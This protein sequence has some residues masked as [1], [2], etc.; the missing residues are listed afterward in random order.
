MSVID[1]LN[2]A[3]IIVLEADGR[4]DSRHGY[5][6][7]IV[8]RFTDFGIKTTLVSIVENPQVL[9]RLPR[10]P[11]VLSGGM[12]EV[13]A[14]VDWVMKTKAHIFR[15]IRQNRS[16]QENRRI[17]VFG[18]CFGAQLIAECY[19]KGSVCYLENPEIGVTRITLDDP[20]HPLFDGFEP[21]FDAYTFHYN[22]IKSR[23]FSALSTHYFNNRQFIQA[24][25]IPE[26]SVFGVQFHP[27][28]NHNEMQILFKTYSRLIEKLG[29]NPKDIIESLP[30]LTG[31]SSILRNF[32]DHYCSF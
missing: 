17:P 21:Q 7:P 31:N 18:I 5:G 10:K 27:E 8:R 16:I 20:P 14:D 24:F 22:Q 19:N 12:T 3:D 2:D 15:I 13:T 25:E 9:A 29:F 28:F 6:T 4:I 32:H 26:S 23:D 30:E 11:L 1:N